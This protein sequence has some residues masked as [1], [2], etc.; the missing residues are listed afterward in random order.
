MVDFAT[1]MLAG[2]DAA[3]LRRMLFDQMRKA[4]LCAV[5]K[6]RHRLAPTSARELP[7]RP[8]LYRLGGRLKKAIAQAPRSRR[9]H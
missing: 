1:C 8:F 9:D 4:D 6:L 3:P 2:R 7:P 5:A